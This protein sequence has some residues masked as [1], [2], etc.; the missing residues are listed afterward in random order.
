MGGL[1]PRKRERPHAPGRTEV[2]ALPPGELIMKSMMNF[3]SSK[4]EQRAKSKGK[5][6]YV[7]SRAI[8]YPLGVVTAIA[9]RHLWQ[10]GFSFATVK[11]FKFLY[12]TGFA[13]CVSFTFTGYA[14]LRRWDQEHAAVQDRFN[15]QR[16]EFV[17]ATP[18][19]QTRHP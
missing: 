6:L 10:Y 3:D 15:Q 16:P 4:R 12:E 9:L 14:A 17:S 19:D 5:N 2:R 11:S 7:L 18:P 13:F 1:T 8:A